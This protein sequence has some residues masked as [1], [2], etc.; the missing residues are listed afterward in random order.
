MFSFLR[1]P[2]LA[3]IAV[4]FMALAAL[5]LR[6]EPARAECAGEDGGAGTV[7]EI[8]DGETLILDDGR[9]VR[10]VGVLSPKRARGG[11][12]SDARTDKQKADHDL[13][14]G[15]KIAQQLGER[16]RDRYGRLLAQVRLADEAGTWVQGKLV[17]DG[18]ARVISSPD[19]R[20]C[21][22]ELLALEDEAR[23][24]QTG[25]WQTGF[26]AIRHADAEDLLFRLVEGYEIVEG[27][28]NNVTEIRGRTYI[29]FGQNWRRDFTAFVPAESNRLFGGAGAG[30]DAAAFALTDLGGRRIRV[31]GW[32][33][34]FNGPSITVTHPEQI[35]I[36]DRNQAA[37]SH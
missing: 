3:N 13:T 17:S 18:L 35:E 10:L 19:N 4:V 12:M 14:L 37:Q 34:N 29:N 22:P 11:P 15:K 23:K 27:Q 6:S 8:N 1:L 16:K 32:M 25:L 28:V 36:L 33:K 24:A 20:L 7:V 30:Q 31:R 5:A 2:L 26:F 9:A 21:V